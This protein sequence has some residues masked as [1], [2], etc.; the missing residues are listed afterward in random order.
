MFTTDLGNLYNRNIFKTSLYIYIFQDE[1]CRLM[2]NLSL[3]MTTPGSSVSISYVMNWNIENY[4]LGNSALPRLLK[5]TLSVYPHWNDFTGKPIFCYYI[6]S[7]QLKISTKN[8]PVGLPSSPIKI[9]GKSVLGFL[10]YDRTNRQT[11]KQRLQL[12]IYRYWNPK[13]A[14]FFTWS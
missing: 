2:R 12:Y 14:K 13:F 11:D 7:F 1:K 4:L 8:I 3:S 10:S 6:R 5:V 9:W